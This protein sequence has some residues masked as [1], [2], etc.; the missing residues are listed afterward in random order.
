MSSRLAAT[1]STDI[2]RPVAVGI[3]D[4][5]VELHVLHVERHVLLGLPADHLAGL[6]LLH[7]VHRDLLDDHVAAADGRRRPASA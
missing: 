6:R 1:R 2:C 4:L 3:Q 5:E 7:A